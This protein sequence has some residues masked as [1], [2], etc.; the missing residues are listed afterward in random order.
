MIRFLPFGIEL[1]LVVFCL[2]DCI[3]SDEGSIRNLGKGWWILLIL[4][5][6][7]VG[8][9]AWLVAGRPVSGPR[10]R[11]PWPSTRTAGFPEY[12]RPRR[13]VAPD[14]DPEFLAEMRKGNA[15]Q[16]ELLKKWEDD[17]RRR[18][19]EL[20]SDDQPPASS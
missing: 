8:A 10:R 4:F 6:P 15:E 12:E 1:F 2:I 13:S 11:A 7:L 9:I 17:L 20:G 18:E 14:D 16:E 19:R 3:Q 5:F